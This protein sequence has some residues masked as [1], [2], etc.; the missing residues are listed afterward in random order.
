MKK[1]LSAC[2]IV[3]N[4]E[5]VIERCLKSIINIVD[6]IVVVDTG[7]TDRTIEL[8]KK[9]TNDIY[10][11][12]WD[13]NFSNARNYAAEQAKSEWIL[14]L[15]ADEFVDRENLISIKRQL[16]NIKVESLLVKILNFI[17]D[18]G[19]Q[20]L[21]HEAQ[22]IYKRNEK[23]KFTRSIHEQLV[24]NNNEILT[25]QEIDLIIYHSGYLNRIV[26]EK[27]KHQRNK[28]LLRKELNSKNTAFDY[29]NMGNEEY[30]INNYEES[31]RNYQK[32]YA[33]SSG[34]LYAWSEICVLQIINCLMN[35]GRQRDALDVIN[36]AEKIWYDS[37]DLVCLKAENLYNIYR[38]ND[39]LEVLNKA[40]R[41]KNH[42]KE[43]ILDVRLKDFYLNYLLGKIYDMQGEFKKSIVHYHQALQAN[44]VHKPTLVNLIKLLVDN[45]LVEEFNEVIEGVSYNLDLNMMKLI[46]NTLLSLGEIELAVSFGEKH[47]S[48][49]D[50]ERVYF[51]RDFIIKSKSEQSLEKKITRELIDGE[52]INFFDLL[53]VISEFGIELLHYDF[54]DNELEVIKQF[55][56][57]PQNQPELKIIKFLESC[58]QLRK[59][60]TFERIIKST[61]M[62]FSND[63]KFNVIELLF[64]NKFE[65]VAWEMILDLDFDSSQFPP[66]ILKRIADYMIKNEYPEEIIIQFLNSIE[67]EKMDFELLTITL[68]YYEMKD[69]KEFEKILE[70]SIDL[71]PDSNYLLDKLLFN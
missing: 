28:P 41:N 60:D 10:Y 29:F 51:K 3:K 43:G 35:L 23:V 55:I 69:R 34:E 42:Y 49:I 5:N 65:S 67:Y 45:N 16:S 48:K 46:T 40:H 7:S 18:G 57:N 36:D 19:H 20:I 8:V 2:L 64:D 63:Y 66:I 32:A 53:V 62:P 47:F 26:N 24:K 12:N 33:N 14:V 61:F 11:Y 31:L 4:E 37:I 21:K 71:Y 59:F 27:N 25:C 38:Y 56:I 13:A 17:G 50:L 52:L 44:N 39:A 70:Y 6:E 30:S 22:R 9:Y 54:T 58:I 1:I 68:E 15:D